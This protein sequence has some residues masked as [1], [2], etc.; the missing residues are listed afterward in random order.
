MTY[1]KLKDYKSAIKHTDI[2][3]YILLVNKTKQKQTI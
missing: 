2:V 1:M 3:Y